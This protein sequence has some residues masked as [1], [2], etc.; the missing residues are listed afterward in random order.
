MGGNTGDLIIT[1]GNKEDLIIMGGNTRGIG[2]NTTGGLII[3]RCFW[4]GL[5]WS[6]ELQKSRDC[7]NL[8]SWGTEASITG[9]G[10]CHSSTTISTDVGSSE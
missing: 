6:T 1:G 4:Q 2:G 7:M 8:R 10:D 5:T 9:K 3:N